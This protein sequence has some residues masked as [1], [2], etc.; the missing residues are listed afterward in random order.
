MRRPLL[1]LIPAALL[2]LGTACG[3]ADPVLDASGG[4]GSQAPAGTSSSQGAG[5]ASDASG[6]GGGSS[7]SVKVPD[8]FPLPVFRGGTVT[9]ALK[10]TSDGVST[11]S[12]AIEF[13][14]DP[15]EVADLYEAALKSSGL[16]TSRTEWESGDDRTIM[17]AGFGDKGEGIIG[18][19]YNKA[20]KTGTANI[21]WMQ[22]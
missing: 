21:V 20:K 2:L 18:I 12:V 7:S 10:I 15:K 13:A 17:V 11:F 14:G 16:E 9:D 3:G 4:S 22:K 5:G 8:E 6:G 19:E 1:S